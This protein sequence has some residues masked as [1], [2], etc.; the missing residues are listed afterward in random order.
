MHFQSGASSGP[1][2]LEKRHEP[3]GLNGRFT[4]GKL[5][6]ADY[7]AQ[8]RDMIRT[9][10]KQTYPEFLD[11]AALEKIVQ[12][13]APYALEPLGDN[14]QG[15]SKKYRRGI[16]LSH[17]LS[18]SPYF[19]H[20]L[21]EFFQASGF[22]VFV[23]L[24]PGHGT[25]PGDLLH[26]NWHEWAKAV[27]Y[28]IN[29]LA[30]EVD[31]VYLGGYSAGG[32]I[33]LLQSLHDKR[34]H[35]LFL[36][37][38]AIDINHAARFANVHKLWSWLWPR[39]KWLDIKP[40]KD[41]YKYESFAKNVAAQMFHLAQTLEK[42]LQKRKLEIPVFVVA[43]EDDKTVKIEATIRLMERQL[44]ADTKC[45]VYS[46]DP[47][48]FSHKLMHARID[49]VNS[50]FPEQKILSSAHTAILL[51]ADDPHYGVNGEY[52][53]CI[54]YYPQKMEKYLACMRRPQECWL[55]EI[56]EK[57]LKAGNLRRLMYN[58]NFPALKV[59]LQEF[60]QTLED[61]S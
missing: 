56:N 55:G 26:V 34:I 58:P 37:A 53:N 32:A 27:A 42:K 29:R 22:R 44:H 51:A 61:K 9:V 12:G 49:W 20:H 18:D 15:Q 4:G 2:P 10:R 43:S 54:H 52:A 45:I 6:F 47:A 23:I 14:V 33:S 60:I 41:V 24:L 19:M 39:S 16:L 11:D 48:R 7:V 28:G 3:S 5:S 8:T 17:G 1:P 40:D 38:P 59:A 21:A 31:Q 35:G 25:R 13:N 30:E 57:N 50:L 36:F 46:T